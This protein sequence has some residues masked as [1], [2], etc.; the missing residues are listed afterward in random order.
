M[1]QSMNS[2]Q[3]DLKQLRRQLRYKRRHLDCFQQRQAAQAVLNRLRRHPK[4]RTAQ[5]VG[6]YL[7]AFGEIATTG[8]IELCFQQ[9]KEVYLPKICN[10]NQHLL[11]VKI[12]R[13]QFYA[14]RFSLHRLGMLEPQQ[15]GIAVQYLDVL[16]M[17]LLACDRTGMRLGM[18]GGFY[19]RTLCKSDHRPYRLGLA[20]DFQRLDFI[21]PHQAWDQPLHALCTPQ[22][23]QYFNT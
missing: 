22:H 15:R 11:W 23:Y 16:F 14:R 12:S 19:D 13:Q 8:L 9:H 3:L 6:L 2:H 17:P 18:G 4:L 21:L 10:M 7:D 1:H 20:H 5:K